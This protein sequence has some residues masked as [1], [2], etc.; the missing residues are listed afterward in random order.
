M[1]SI[2][3]FES[4]HKNGKKNERYFLCKSLTKT[5]KRMKNNFF[6]T[7]SQKQKKNGKYFLYESLTKKEKEQNLFAL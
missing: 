5:E 1:K 2:F 3:L 6:V 4:C 7:L